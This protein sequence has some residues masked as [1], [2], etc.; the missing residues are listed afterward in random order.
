MVLP[1]QRGEEPP[2]SCRCS[3]LQTTPRPVNTLRPTYIGNA[4]RLPEPVHGGPAKTETRTARYPEEC[5]NGVQRSYI[6]G[7]ATMYCGLNPISKWPAVS[8]ATC[9]QSADQGGTQ[10]PERQRPSPER[11][12]GARHMAG[13]LLPWPH[14]ILTRTPMS[15][16]YCL[17]DEEINGS[18][19]EL[20]SLPQILLLAQ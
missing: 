8:K 10:A 11:V 6:Y 4:A 7:S 15:G 12:P 14:V 18:L 1:H 19:E 20:S 17:T 3:Q 13:A 9:G 2:Q 5:D 16:P